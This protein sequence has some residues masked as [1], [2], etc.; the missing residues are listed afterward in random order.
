VFKDKPR[1]ISFQKPSP[2][3]TYKLTIAGELPIPLMTFLLGISGVKHLQG[4]WYLPKE[5]RMLEIL[6]RDVPA[7]IELSD[8]VKL[9]YNN[10]L[11]EE[12]QGVALI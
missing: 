10:I 9:W 8:E 3:A 1:K 12:Q 7:P 2:K 6:L 4:L 11:S 5:P